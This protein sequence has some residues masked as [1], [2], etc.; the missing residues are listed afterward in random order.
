MSRFAA[1]RKT[2]NVADAETNHW[3][4][5]GVKHRHQNRCLC[6]RQF[7]FDHRV[8]PIQGEIERVRIE[9]HAETTRVARSVSLV[10]G[11]T[12]RFFDQRS[13]PRPKLL[14]ARNQT[15]RWVARFITAAEYVLG[16]ITERTGVGDD[17]SRFETF[18]LLVIMLENRW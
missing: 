10:Y 9:L 18:E 17:A 16:Q 5:V 14:S 6:F 12:A 13:V 2:T 15:A 7:G 4:R 8:R 11:T 1:G 3:H